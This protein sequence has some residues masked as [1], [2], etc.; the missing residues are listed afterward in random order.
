M[1]PHPSRTARRRPHPL[2]KLFGQAR[3]PDVRNFGSRHMVTLEVS[4]AEGSRVQQRLAAVGYSGEMA[5]L[6]GLA[7]LEKQAQQKARLE[8]DRFEQS[9]P[10]ALQPPMPFATRATRQTGEHQDFCEDT[11][12]LAGESDE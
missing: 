12:G 3:G 1:N 10:P 9:L 5:L 2:P 8:R 7:E 11:R 6:L 4:F